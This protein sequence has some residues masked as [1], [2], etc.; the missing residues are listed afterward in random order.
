MSLT[1]SYE[2]PEGGR[3]WYVDVELSESYEDVVNAACVLWRNRLPSDEYIIGRYL[4]RQIRRQGETEWARLSQTRFVQLVRDAPDDLE[5]RLELDI[6]TGHCR[7]RETSP[8]SS[9]EIPPPILNYDS[10]NHSGHPYLDDSNNASEIPTNNPSVPVPMPLTPTS[11]IETQNKYR[12]SQAR[13]SVG[14]IS[15]TSTSNY[16]TEPLLESSILPHLPPSPVPK[17][18]TK[19]VKYEQGL[20]AFSS[21]RFNDAR[22]RFQLAV[23]ECYETGDAYQEAECLLRLGMTCRHLKDYSNAALHLSNARKIYES[24]RDCQREVLSCE[25]NLARVSEDQ[26]NY[27]EALRAYKEIQINARS[28]RSQT[29]EAWC[30]YFIGRLYNRIRQYED[31][32]Q[33]LSHAIRTAKALKNQEIEAYAT[34]ESGHSAERQQHWELAIQCYEMSLSMFKNRGRGQWADNENRVKKRL[35]QLRAKQNPR[36]FGIFRRHSTSSA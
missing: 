5:F 27:H 18:A 25:R 28:V 19:N 6:Q 13:L 31:A 20:S 23:D 3:P 17:P 15:S 34:E 16:Q 14:T 4:A 24:L 21:G 9:L 36:K 2:P 12:R 35:E 1:I 7:F 10:N 32:L 11:I 33:H 8:P 29:E 30:D 22:T 26:G